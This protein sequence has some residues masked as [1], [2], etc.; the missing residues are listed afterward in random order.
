MQSGGATN[1]AM[2]GI[3]SDVIQTGKLTQMVH[4]ARLIFQVRIFHIF[5]HYKFTM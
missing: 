1:H 2:C 3:L 5:W 4:D